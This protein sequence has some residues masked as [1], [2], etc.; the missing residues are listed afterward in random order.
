VSA[1]I[2]GAIGAPLRQLTRLHYRN[3]PPPPGT[4][5]RELEFKGLPPRAFTHPH[6]QGEFGEALTFT[7]MAADRW[8]PVN[9]KPGQGPQGIDGIFWRKTG[10]AFEFRLIETKTNTSDHK[11][12]S[13]SHKKLLGNLDTLYA[14][15][16]DERLQGLY[17]HIAEGLRSGSPHIMTELWRHNLYRGI[18]S[19]SRLDEDGQPFGP[20]KWRDSIA[21]MEA[22]AAGVAEMDRGGQI[23]TR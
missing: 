9:G 16:G 18:T 20:L 2:A 4:R 5:P 7:M 8:R 1:A 12:Y 10:T 11:P 14:T 23:L 21:K 15:A 6:R 3:T 19:I 13:M 22:L 17:A